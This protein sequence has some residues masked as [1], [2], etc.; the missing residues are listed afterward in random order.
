M[1]I[2]KFQGIFLNCHSSIFDSFQTVSF[3]G[4]SIFESKFENE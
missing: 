1:L 3:A 4:M 2:L